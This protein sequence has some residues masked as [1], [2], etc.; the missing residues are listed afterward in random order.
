MP[1]CQLSGFP[2]IKAK[3]LCHH[4]TCQSLKV[5]PWKCSTENLEEPC[6]KPTPRDACWRCP[7]CPKVKYQ[8]LLAQLPSHL[9]SGHVQPAR[10]APE[11]AGAPSLR[12]SV[13]TVPGPGQHRAQQ[14]EGTLPSQLCPNAP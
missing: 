1:W 11:P 4:P 6:L 9:P 8:A 13:P 5:G 14:V 2:T 10:W 3:I 7:L 12:P